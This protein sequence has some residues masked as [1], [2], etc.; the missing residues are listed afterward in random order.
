M[1][2][3]SVRADILLAATPCLTYKHVDRGRHGEMKNTIIGRR[4]STT[5][6]GLAW[7]SLWWEWRDQSVR[8]FEQVTKVR[9]CHVRSTTQPIA[10]S[11]TAPRL[12][13]E[14]FCLIRIWLLMRTCP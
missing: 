10:Q 13:P 11:G 7:L 4:Y 1:R 2:N 8:L 3:S 6:V 12:L 5:E 14:A 9:V